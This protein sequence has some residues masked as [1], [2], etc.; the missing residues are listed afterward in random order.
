[1]RSSAPYRAPWAAAW[2]TWCAWRSRCAEKNC[3]STTTPASAPPP[4]AHNSPLTTHHSPAALASGR[5]W[6]AGARVLTV[7][8]PSCSLSIDGNPYRGSVGHPRVEA[9]CATDRSAWS[10][11]TACSLRAVLC[12]H[13]TTL[14]TF[15]T[16]QYPWALAPQASRCRAH[17]HLVGEAEGG[18]GAHLLGVVFNGRLVEAQHHV[19]RVDGGAAP[20]RSRQYATA[21]PPPHALHVSWCLRSW[22][23]S[24]GPI[25][26][27]IDD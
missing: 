20:W 11:C 7:C 18:L 5:A 1:M 23:C 25:A 14:P 8:P 21:S 19:V 2:P 15:P 22:M 9:T 13:R 6:I 3:T 24:Q 27:T 4:E 10:S 16:L 26:C 17:T 12:I